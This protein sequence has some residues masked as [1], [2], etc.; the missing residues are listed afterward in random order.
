MKIDRFQPHAAVAITTWRRGSTEEVSEMDNLYAGFLGAGSPHLDRQTIVLLRIL[1]FGSIALPFI[2][3]PCAE[4][5]AEVAA[6]SW[7]SRSAGD[8]I[9]SDLLA[10]RCVRSALAARESRRGRVLRRRG[11]ASHCRRTRQIRPSLRSDA[12]ESGSAAA[13]LARPRPLARQTD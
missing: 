11:V 7:R 13:P 8:S 10:V 2:L 1:C 12:A 3:S 4:Y 6:P 9:G 5:P